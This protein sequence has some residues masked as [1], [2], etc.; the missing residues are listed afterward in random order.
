MKSD[1]LI[2]WEKNFEVGIDKIDAQHKVLVQIINDFISAKLEHKENE[3]LGQTLSKLV[4]YT[5][6]HFADE[7]KIMLEF[8]YFGLVEH[9]GQHN[10]LIKQIVQIL[11]HLKSGS[12][13]VNEE[14]FSLL[15]NWLLKHVLEHDINFSK[16][17]HIGNK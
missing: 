3:I 5:K 16:H 1:K 15:R 8:H 11:Q 13:A 12:L 9:K 2:K 17:Y 6:T 7:E 4:D 14:L 10:I